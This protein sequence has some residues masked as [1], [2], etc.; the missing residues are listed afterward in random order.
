M[1]G[2]LPHC[3]FDLNPRAASIDTPL[4]AFVPYHARRPHAPRRDHRDRRHRRRRRLT[5][6]L[7]RR[8]R[9]AAVAA[10][11]LRARPDGSSA[12]RASAP[13][14]KGVVLESHG[15][16]TWGDTARRLLRH[17]ARR[18]ST[19]RS[20][21][22]STKRTAARRLRRCRNARRRCRRLSALASPPRLMPEIRGGSAAGE[23]P[24]SRPF[25]RQPG[26]ARVRQF[27]TSASVGAAR[28]VLPRPFPAHQDPPLVL[29]FDPAGGDLDASGRRPARASSPPIAT[30]MPPITS[31][32][33]TTTARRCAT[34]TRSSIWCR[35]SA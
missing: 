25:R 14:A 1:V 23:E 8:D 2:Y 32:A 27:A 21:G 15:L 28:H 9:L 7:R 19:G 12:S 29:D 35:A 11:G 10:A 4:H 13:S 26:G 33:V 34:P 30:T 31:A 22:S 3:T 16:F 24:Q 5:G 18:S 17:D 20:P 6:D